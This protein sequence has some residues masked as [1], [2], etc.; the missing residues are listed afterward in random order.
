MCS[1]FAHNFFHDLEEVIFGLCTIQVATLYHIT[2]KKYRVA[3]ID[4]GEH[5]RILKSIYSE[6]ADGLGITKCILAS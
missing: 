5:L 3:E 6:L 2:R 1:Q 4:Q